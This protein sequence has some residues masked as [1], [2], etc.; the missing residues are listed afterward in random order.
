MQVSIGG[1]TA[2]MDG[3]PTGIRSLVAGDAEAGG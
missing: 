3:T 2:E 1:Y